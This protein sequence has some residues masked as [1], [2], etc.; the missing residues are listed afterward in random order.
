MSEIKVMVVDDDI[1]V[2]QALENLIRRHPQTKPYYFSASIDEALVTLVKAKTY[3]D[4]IVH[5]IQFQGTAKSGIEAIADIKKITTHPKILI[6]SMK[7]DQETV[8]A[9]IKA[10][11]DGFVWKNESGEGIVSAIVKLAEGRFVVTPSV[12]EKMLGQ[13][14][15]LDKYVEVLKEGKQ[16]KQLTESLRKTLYLYCY[17]GMSAKEIS[18]ELNLSIHTV[19]SRIKTAYGLL[20]AKSRTEAFEKFIERES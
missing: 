3:P 4:V 12:A 1:Y 10:G 8:M 7:S 9:A 15:K 18:E 6:S 17:C 2:R 13:A 5:D 20:H 19:N 11:A 16:H 14:V